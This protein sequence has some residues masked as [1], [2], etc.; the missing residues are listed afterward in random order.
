MIVAPHS[1]RRKGLPLN[2]ALIIADQTC[3]VSRDAR[4]IATQQVFAPAEIA[5]REKCFEKLLEE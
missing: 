2:L 5:F 1:P 3:S 4:S